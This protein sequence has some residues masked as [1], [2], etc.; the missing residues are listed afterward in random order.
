[1][2][3]S[4]NNLMLSFILSLFYVIRYFLKFYVTY[5]RE[6]ISYYSLF[7]EHY[8][9]IF[10]FLFPMFLWRALI[11][12]SGSHWPGHFRHRLDA[13]VLVDVVNEFDHI[14]HVWTLP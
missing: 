5:L 3:V 13:D 4:R 6:T 9:A 14:E 1:M 12:D 10:Y 7:L 2:I 8:V 11:I